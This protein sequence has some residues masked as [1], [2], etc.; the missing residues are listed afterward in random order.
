M[1]SMDPKSRISLISRLSESANRVSTS[2]GTRT[3]AINGDFRVVL[4]RDQVTRFYKGAEYDSVAVTDLDDE[5]I[6]KINQNPDKVAEDLCN[7]FM[8]DFEKEAAHATQDSTTW[9]TI[10]EKQLDRQRVDLHPRTEESPEQITEKQIPDPSPGYPQGQRPGTYDEITERQLRNEGST[11]Y[12]KSRD[13]GKDR[14]EDRNQVTEKQLDDDKSRFNAPVG[15]LNRGEVGAVFDGGLD[16]QW[17]QIMHKQIQELLSHHEW[18]DPETITEGKDQLESQDG[19]LSRMTAADAQETM[20]QAE[21]ALAKILLASGVVPK[22]LLTVAGRL[23]SH[24]SKYAV[25]ANMIGTYQKVNVSTEDIEEKVAK[26][27]YWG[28]S[29][30]AHENWSPSQTADALIRVLASIKAPAKAIVGSLVGITS[31]QDLQDRI[32]KQTDLLL[33]AEQVEPTPQDEFDIFKRVAAGEFDDPTAEGEAKDGLYSYDG[34]FAEID[35]DPRNREVFAEAAMAHSIAKIS[36]SEPDTELQGL[37]LNVDEENKCFTAIMRDA[38]AGNETKLSQ[39]EI[40]KRAARRQEMADKAL[41]KVASSNATTKEA[42]MP[43]GGQ[44]GAGGP[45]AGPDMMNPEAPPGAGDMGGVPPT[46]SLTQDM[47]PGEGGEEPTGEPKPPGSLCPVCG[48]TDVDVDNGDFRCNNCGGEGTIEVDMNIKKW[49]DVIQETEG[50]GE[51]GVSAEEAVAGTEEMAGA[52]P[53]PEGSVMPSVPVGAS[54]RLTPRTLEK[55]AEKKIKIGKICPRCGSSETDLHKAAASDGLDGYC[56]TCGQEYNF[57]IRGGKDKKHQVFAQ[58]LWNPNPAKCDG[59]V[60][61]LKKAFIESLANYGMTWDEFRSL[62]GTKAQAD[63]VLKIAKAGSLD[64]AN[65]L[66]A[67]LPLEKCAASKRWDDRAQFDKFPS[68]SCRELLKRRWGENATAMS[69]P[70]EGA[71][72]ADCVCDQLERLGIYTDGVAAK[73]ASHMA[74]NDPRVYN[75]IETCQTMLVKAGY[76]LTDAKIATDGLRAAFAPE[77]DLIIEGIIQTAG[78]FDE[79]EPMEGPLD[80]PVSPEEPELP[81]GEM[82]SE[83]EPVGLEEGPEDMGPLGGDKLDLGIEGDTVSLKLDTLLDKLDQLVDVLMQMSNGDIDDSLVEVEPSIDVMEGEEA[84]PD[85]DVSE[86]TEETVE[87]PEEEGTEEIP[88]LKGEEETEEVGAEGD[89]VKESEPEEEGGEE[90]DKECSTPKPC[91]KP[92]EKKEPEP[93]AKPEGE[94]PNSEKETT[95]EVAEETTGEVKEASKP[96]APAEV[97]QKE[98]SNVT[99]EQ[100]RQAEAARLNSMLI[101]MKTGSIGSQQSGLDNVFNGL[102]EQLAKQQAAKAAAEQ[103]GQQKTAEAEG[104]VKTAKSQ[105]SQQ[106]IEYKSV[107]QK[108]VNETPAQD[109]AGKVQD[110]GKMGDEESFK[111]N[112][113][114]GFDAPRAQATIGKETAENTVSETGDQPSIPQGSPAMSGETIRPEKQT[115]VDGNQGSNERQASDEAETKVASYSV[116]KTHALYPKLLAKLAEGVHTVTLNDGNTYDVKPE[117]TDKLVLAKVKQEE[118]QKIEK[119]EGVTTKSLNKKDELADDP[120]TGNVRANKTHERAEDE[121]KPNDGVEEFDTPKAPNDGRIS[122]EEDSGKAEEH[123]PVAMG[124]GVNPKYDQNES[125]HPEKIDETL[126]KRNDI[127]ATAST[128]TDQ[129]Y[130][131]QVAGEMLKAGMIEGVDLVAKIEELSRLTPETLKVVEQSIVAKAAS[132]QEAK[133]AAQTQPGMQKQGTPGASEVLAA[134]T[135]ASAATRP[136]EVP[137]DD[138][139]GQIQQAFTLDKRNRDYERFSQEHPVDRMFR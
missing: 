138:L 88:G 65:G 39:D 107:K 136:V 114:D 96:A 102:V 68:A 127:S 89:I 61:P 60:T 75:P 92:V 6:D 126:G 4:A 13:S 20:K 98:A 46:E 109:T 77:E 85:L 3:E 53:A 42:Q 70:C 78:L 41:G 69:G 99:T 110:G 73:V 25:L 116:S 111:T 79:E 94:Q 112:V 139:T 34:H 67:P 40:D 11:F 14:D 47:A 74:S 108:K 123:P 30:S 86:V 132:D 24:P 125:I 9:N 117:G 7:C 10:Q 137:G 21:K 48:S 18:T 80:V 37:S 90:E 119:Q 124:G 43:A 27:R 56:W 33:T 122:K 63:M 54:A 118:Q 31:R 50:E 93:Q 95:A 36:K 128:N 121:Q 64:I 58:F 52:E 19:E 1:S 84:A 22:Q 45:G 115:M 82:T 32:E 134:L 66:L 71:K 130:A 49:P 51:E 129:K 8:E 104:T 113:E 12:N 103:P 59:C 100:N 29:A 55:I 106:K 15:G 72:L 135:T 5:I 26:A 131:A 91:S 83:P 97:I 44:M 120:D 17:Q 35:A 87:S 105:D 38:K 57:Q 81:G 23:V 28:K 133:T 101:K 62:P 2:V 76:S 16:S